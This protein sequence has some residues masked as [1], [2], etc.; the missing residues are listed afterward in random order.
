V[1]RSRKYYK[2]VIIWQ[3]K[4]IKT[5]LTIKSRIGLSRGIRAPLTIK[6]KMGFSKGIA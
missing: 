4:G 2:E 1:L 3:Y 5:L 6:S